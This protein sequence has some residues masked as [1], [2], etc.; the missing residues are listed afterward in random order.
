MSSDGDSGATGPGLRAL[1][2]SHEPQAAPAVVGQLLQ[3]R[4]VS[5]AQHVILQDGGPADVDFPDPNDFDLV[6]SFGSF[7]NAYDPAAADW[8]SA[9]VGLI[10]QIVDDEVPFLGVCFGGQLLCLALGGD[11][12]RAPEG[13]EE[14]GVVEMV[15]E[16]ESLPVPTGPWFAWHEDRC[17]LPDGIEVL[18]RTDRAVQMFRTGRAVGLQFHPEVDID[19]V[20][21]WLRIGEHHLPQEWTS[22]QLLR[23]WSDAEPEAHRN[24]EQLIDWLLDDV[25]GGSR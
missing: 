18:A 25:V 5:T 16:R 20:A 13:A 23:V 22:E 15:P 9:E 24:C 17:S 19:L 11:V 8:V 21:E 6:V 7:T 12:E 2:I 3:E 14:I 1:L 10:R 4:G